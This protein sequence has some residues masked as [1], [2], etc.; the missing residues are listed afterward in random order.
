MELDAGERAT[1]RFELA[2]RDLSTWDA[3]SAAWELARGEFT[4]TV[5][6]SSR[7]AAALSTSFTV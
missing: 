3:A 5:G 4:A 1:V 6:T 2:P 7:D